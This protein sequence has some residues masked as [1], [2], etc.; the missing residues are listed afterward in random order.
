MN[1]LLPAKHCEQ[2][3]GHVLSK[4]GRLIPLQKLGGCTAKFARLS[5]VV[6]IGGHIEISNNAIF[7]VDRKITR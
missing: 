7:Q 1:L 4:T 6:V 2:A 5:D 3:S